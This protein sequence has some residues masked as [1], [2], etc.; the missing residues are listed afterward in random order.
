MLAFFRRMMDGP[1]TDPGLS[2]GLC[3]CQHTQ[4][5][6]FIINQLII[7]CH[8][9]DGLSQVSCICD[10]VCCH[11]QL[12][13]SEHRALPGTS[14]SPRVRRF[15]LQYWCPLHVCFR[16]RGGEGEEVAVAVWS[17]RS[18]AEYL[19]IFRV[20]SSSPSFYSCNIIAL[21]RKGYIFLAQPF[22]LRSEC[23]RNTD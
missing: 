22:S 12:S 4:S 18:I 19:L 9:V 6:C 5:P 7:A 1:N 15:T 17:Y 16:E 2:V 23:T 14:R 21:G 8:F 20:S 3:F 11:A 13:V 10:S